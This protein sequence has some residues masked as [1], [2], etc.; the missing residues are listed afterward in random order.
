M[1]AVLNCH[2]EGRVIDTRNTGWLLV[3]SALVLLMTPGLAFFDAGLARS[4]MLRLLGCISSSIYVLLLWCGYYVGIALL[5]ALMWDIF[6]GNL[7]W[8]GLRDVSASAPGP[9]SDTVSHQT[10]MIFQAMF[11]I[12]TP[13]LW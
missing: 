7:R 2:M 5:L 13:A 10:F 8:V 11:V 4:K 3:S 1:S 12:I 6:F 9:Y